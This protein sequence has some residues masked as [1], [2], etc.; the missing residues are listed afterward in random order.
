MCTK[1]NKLD[2]LE[3]FRS[4]HEYEIESEDD[5]RIPNQLR[6]QSRRFSLL[7]TSEGEGFRSKI[8]V[9]CDDLEYALSV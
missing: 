2:T 4:E 5:F 8:A 9:L 3:S 6:S 1:E 7:L